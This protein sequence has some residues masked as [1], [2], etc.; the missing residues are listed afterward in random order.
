MVDADKAGAVGEDSLDLQEVDHVGYTLHD[1]LFFQDIGG[2]VH[3]LLYCFPLPGALE[4]TGCDIRYLFGII[5]FQSLV[6]SALGNHSK[7]QQFEL[8][9]L[10]GC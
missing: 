6:E 7:R 3:H 10:F 8:V 4:G 2:V 9:K 1:L 5:E